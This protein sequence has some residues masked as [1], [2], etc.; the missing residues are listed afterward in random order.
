MGND[1]KFNKR[2]DDLLNYIQHSLTSVETKNATLVAL[3][4]AVFVGVLSINQNELCL[5][6]ILNISMLPLLIAVSIA[7]ISFYPCKA[8]VKQ[9][10]KKAKAVEDLFDCENIKIMG[11]KQLTNILISELKDNTI[12]DFE[13][14]KIINIYKTAKAASRKHKLFRL[15]QCGFLRFCIC[16]WSLFSICVINL[17][18]KFTIITKK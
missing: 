13:Q 17:K 7:S 14:Y 6:L 5:V 18:N 4:I 12:S 3:S 2:I 10:N 9:N 11:Q 16:F 1:V 8:I 15:G